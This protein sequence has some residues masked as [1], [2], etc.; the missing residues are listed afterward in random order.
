MT[1]LTSSTALAVLLSISSLNIYA[2]GIA[3]AAI[4]PGAV[5]ASVNGVAIE[6]NALDNA[7]KQAKAR[8]LTDTPELRATVKSQLIAKELLRQE[9][10]KKNLAADPEVQSAANEARDAAMLQKYLRDAV[11]PRPVSD[12]DVKVYYDKV[13]AALGPQEYKTRMIQTVDEASA[14]LALAEIKTGK[15]FADVAKQFSKA[16]SAVNGGALDWV[17]FKLPLVDGQTQG[18]PLPLAEKVLALKSGMV[19][20]QPVQWQNVWYIVKIDEVRPT[21]IP[22]FEKVKSALK[23]TLVQKEIE[24]AGTELVAGL[25]KNAKISDR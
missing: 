5:V 3:Q 7:M 16:Q 1:R 10:E 14:K 23:Q 8:G 2:Q 4:L 13:V 20:A 6:Q 25:V 21:R 18:Y 11:K 24:R 15:N 9:A 12:A 17:S 19:T 22:D